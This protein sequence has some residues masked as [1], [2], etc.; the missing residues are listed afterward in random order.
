M[1]RKID[2][3]LIAWK[4]SP[5]RQPLLILG[6]RQV[7]K[8]YAVQRFART[9]Y[10]DYAYFNFEEQAALQ[11]IFKSGLEVQKLLDSLSAYR[12]TTITPKRT[13]VIFDEVQACPAALTSLKYFS[14][15]LPHLHII[16]TGSLIGVAS[17]HQGLSFPVGKVEFAHLQ[18]LDF[19]EFL[20]ACGQELLADSIRDHFTEPRAFALHERALD[21]LDAY[22]LLGGMPAVVAAYCG[23][24]DKQIALES[25]LPIRLQI[26]NSYQADMS[27]YVSPTQSRRILASYLSLPAQLAKD[28]AKFQYKLIAKGAK[29]SLFGDALDWL[30]QASIVLKVQRVEQPL[31]PLAGNKDLSAFK[32]YS[33]DCGLLAEL[34]NITSQEL[35]PMMP[36]TNRRGAVV[37]NYVASALAQTRLLYD[38]ELY[39][40]KDDSKSGGKAEIDFLI[41]HKGEV[42]PLEVKSGRRTKSL[43]LKTYMQRY[44]PSYGIRLSRN[45]FAHSDDLLSLPL[46]AAFCLRDL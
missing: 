46:Y 11:E 40:W 1:K 28:N 12:G 37:E 35:L 9:H 16:A 3:Q 29:S 43:S 17:R 27:K 21:Y 34:L 2:A 8:T 44:K 23:E 26:L 14:E 30:E 33:N 36:D 20:W 18:P 6:A 39:Y 42:I 24:E 32:L 31:L 22:L 13:L 7:G 38:S 41:E 45:N 4:N 25:A 19:E 15:K 5:A 10:E